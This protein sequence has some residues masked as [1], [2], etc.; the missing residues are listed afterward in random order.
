MADAA[1]SLSS[2]DRHTLLTQITNLL[3]VLRE[4]RQYDSSFHHHLAFPHDHLT[5]QLTELQAQVHTCISAHHDT[6]FASQS[7]APPSKSRDC[8]HSGADGCERPAFGLQRWSL[9]DG[10]LP[11]P[12]LTSSSPIQLERPLT[13]KHIVSAFRR[14]CC[15]SGANEVICNAALYSLT[16]FVESRCAF[17]TAAGLTSIMETAFQSRCEV[18]DAS[19]HEVFV[20]RLAHLFVACLTHP[21]SEELSEE[22]YVS[23]F[24]WL[25]MVYTREDSV[26]VREMLTSTFER[27]TTH[28]FKRVAARLVSGDAAS[29]VND[30]YLMISFISVLVSG[31][32]TSFHEDGQPN[33]KKDMKNTS[34]TRSRK[35]AGVGPGV[36][37]DEFLTLDLQLIGLNMA[38][39]ALCSLRTHAAVLTDAAPVLKAVENE[40]CRALLIA[41]VSTANNILMSHILRTVHLVSEC[42][43]NN[44]VPQIYSFISVLHLTPLQVMESERALGFPGLGVR[45]GGAGNSSPVLASSPASR[46]PFTSL[47]EI[48]ARRVL[49]LESLA[50]FFADA[51]F[52]VFCF[53]HYDLSWR[54][55]S[56]LPSVLYLLEHT[57]AEE[58]RA[59]DKMGASPSRAAS[60]KP[61]LPTATDDSGQSPLPVFLAA[62]AVTN[63]LVSLNRADTS[64]ESASVAPLVREGFDATLL[65]VVKQKKILQNFQKLFNES[66]LRKGIFYL[67]QQ[68]VTVPAGA[69]YHAAV[70]EHKT[71]L[72][73]HEPADGRAIGHLLHR[74]ATWVDKRVL[75]NYIGEL[76][77]EEEEHHDAETREAAR[78]MLGSA[79][80]FTEQLIGYMEEFDFKG[81]SLISS[82]REMVYNVCLPGESQK[83]DRV[84]E[85]FA[86]EWYRQNAHVDNDPMLN[87]FHSESG[88]FILSFA[89]IMLNTD[90]HSRSVEKK[91]VFSEFKNMNRGID[92]DQDLPE[93]YLLSVFADVV[94]HE[95]IM[96]EMM[97]RGYTN[98]TAWGLDMRKTST[99]GPDDILALWSLTNAAPEAGLQPAELRALA[100]PHIFSLVADPSLC[101]F[102]ATLWRSAIAISSPP[103]QGTTI[104]ESLDV[105]YRTAPYDVLLF[106]ST[107]KG[108]AA[109]LQASTEVASVAVADNC[110]KLLLSIVSFAESSPL[111]TMEAIAKSAPVLLL[112]RELLY[113]IP[114]ASAARAEQCWPGIARTLKHLQQLGLF[115]VQLTPQSRV[116]VPAHTQRFLLEEPALRVD[117]LEAACFTLKSGAGSGSGWLSSLFGGTANPSEEAKRR[118]SVEQFTQRVQGFPDILTLLQILKRVDGAARKELLEVLCESSAMGSTSVEALFNTCYA[119]ALLSGWMRTALEGADPAADPSLYESVTHTVLPFFEKTLSFVFE[120]NERS[121]LPAGSRRSASVIADRS[122]CLTAEEHTR[123]SR[124]VYHMVQSSLA[125][126]T[127]MA[128]S[129]ALAPNVLKVVKFLLRAPRKTFTFTVA[130]PLSTFVY[131]WAEY[132]RET[133]GTPPRPSGDPGRDAL[134]FNLL[135]TVTMATAATAAFG[136]DDSVIEQL[137]ATLHIIASHQLYDVMK[138]TKYLVDAT[139]A[140][141]PLYRSSGGGGPGTP[142]RTADGDALPSPT[143]LP[144]A[145]SPIDALSCCC[146]NVSRAMDA[147]CRDDSGGATSEAWFQLWLLSLSGVSVMVQCA[148]S[149]REGMDALLALQRSLLSPE[150]QE[151]SAAQLSTLYEQV[152]FPLVEKICAPQAKAPGSG[153]ARPSLPA[154]V[155][156]DIKCRIL[157][158]L[159]KPALRSATVCPTGDPTMLTLWRRLVGTLYAIYTAYPAEGGGAAAVAEETLQM[160][161][162]VN[163]AVK[164]IVIV[165]TTVDPAGPGAA[166][167]PD[168]ELRSQIAAWLKPF[169]FWDEVRPLLGGAPPSA[170]VCSAEVAARGTQEESAEA[171]A[172]GESP[173]PA[174]TE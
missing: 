9:T 128:S 55:P 30:G 14:V 67:L 21:K 124:G 42:M 88:A 158:L 71:W 8:S 167:A 106:R 33:M 68:A 101:V 161:E 133:V 95:V 138:E 23:I 123:W 118:R 165:L 38:Q 32:I 34:P 152:L 163:E 159:P 79:T 142:P 141:A 49:L 104:E 160:R 155:S 115:S 78:R 58:E 143:A 19:V 116:S 61:S 25:F 136:A 56:M 66:P 121:V 43:P 27:A 76:G 98:D 131:M 110:M 173:V 84:M 112:L 126:A 47:A 96:S 57:A 41:G 26:L 81:K 91:M 145:T 85:T 46:L 105:A 153:G 28:F 77:K 132:F 168:A 164:N 102:K 135:S 53:T 22:L 6:L 16:V 130:K 117:I 97:D 99:N 63:L 157:N 170:A 139:V 103:A 31:S 62:T 75:G 147:I 59:A 18:T 29:T 144:A 156:V 5:Q 35:G 51:S 122:S 72:I 174:E 107:L 114:L 162:V 80:F 149:V 40:L 64:L 137:C 65:H 52:C 3:S 148:N 125:L 134:R 166:A 69:D 151:L 15:S 4:S 90:Q 54:Y 20:V 45:K 60:E 83:I 120:V 108:V 150:T 92:N 24:G 70:A 89:I 12:R 171:E 73:I 39:R 146:Q 44:L 37:L 100:L 48:Q 74:L 119:A 113:L 11:K 154:R 82:I 13:E 127:V 129:E 93:E 109:L 10:L 2:D 36:A 17:I 94:E 172:H 1:V 87:P 111:R 140:L 50:E 7:S 169:D 86:N